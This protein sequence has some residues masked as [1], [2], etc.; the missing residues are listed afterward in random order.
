MGSDGEGRKERGMKGDLKKASESRNGCKVWSGKGRAGVGEVK[1]SDLK[2]IHGLSLVMRSY[3]GN[4]LVICRFLWFFACRSSIHN[5]ATPHT[6]LPP[7]YPGA[8]GQT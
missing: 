2:T 4:V 6:L 8:I 7:V 3:Y 1:G 5:E